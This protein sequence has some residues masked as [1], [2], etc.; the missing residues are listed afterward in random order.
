MAQGAAA[1]CEHCGAALRAES[2]YCPECGKATEVPTP[3]INRKH[4]VLGV[5]PS[6]SV[7]ER[8][9]QADAEPA[10]ERTTDIGI[11][12]PPPGQ[13]GRTMLGMPNPTKL[14]GGAAA[15]PAPAPAPAVPE[16]VA[17]VVSKPGKIS[18]KTMLGM[19]GV[20]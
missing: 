3:A 19:P 18:P 17:E 16:V 14:P 11:S 13:L 9:V 20:A 2:F 12:D 10:A 8:R 4:T 15:A 5:M 7:P 6:L 1:V